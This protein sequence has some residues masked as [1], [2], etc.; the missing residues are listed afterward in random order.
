MCRLGVSGTIRQAATED[1]KSRPRQTA[2]FSPRTNAS[3]HLT[4][5]NPRV[6]IAEDPNVALGVG[7]HGSRPSWPKLGWHPT[8]GKFSPAAARGCVGRDTPAVRVVGSDRLLIFYSFTR[9]DFAA[10]HSDRALP[11]DMAD[12]SLT[13]PFFFPIFFHGQP[14]GSRDVEAELVEIRATEDVE[15]CV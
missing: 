3:I 2:D 10:S 6:R 15:L 9:K 8:R 7:P 5:Y 13:A 4:G 12:C 11:T 1:A 14:S